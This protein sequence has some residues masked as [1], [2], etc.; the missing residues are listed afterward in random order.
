M[1]KLDTLCCE[2]PR[3]QSMNKRQSNDCSRPKT[4]TNT[5][6]V[7]ESI[8]RAL[9]ESVP[10]DNEQARE[11]LVKSLQ[12]RMNA[13][14]LEG[15]LIR[16]GNLASTLQEPRISNFIKLPPRPKHKISNKS[17]RSTSNA[18]KAQQAAQNLNAFTASGLKHSDFE[19]K[20]DEKSA[21][22]T[23][24]QLERVTDIVEKKQ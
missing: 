13:I 6:K 24:S 16:L 1:A 18:T 20:F 9:K 7:N 3:T 4:S 12:T 8:Y 17:N 23:R 5:R 10:E 15:N 19:A 11:L 14:K 2:D 22:T 21:N